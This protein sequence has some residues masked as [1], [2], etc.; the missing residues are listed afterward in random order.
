MWNE[1]HG[2]LIVVSENNDET[3]VATYNGTDIVAINAVIDGDIT[4]IDALGGFE[5]LAE[6]SFNDCVSKLEDILD[7]WESEQN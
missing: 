3:L 4:E 1:L 2:S 7:E 6:M 5:F